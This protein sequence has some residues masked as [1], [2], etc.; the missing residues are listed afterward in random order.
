[1]LVSVIVVVS[2]ALD[3]MPSVAVTLSV[4]ETPVAG[5]V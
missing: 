1:M 4:S 5:A 3:A 2:G